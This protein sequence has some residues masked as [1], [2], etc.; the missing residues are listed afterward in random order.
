MTGRTATVDFI[1]CD[2][3]HKTDQSLRREETIGNCTR[4]HDGTRTD[5][6][7]QARVESELMR[8]APRLL[9]EEIEGT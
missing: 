9:L 3:M 5:A 8:L 6:Q 1:V 7:R 4:L 2:A